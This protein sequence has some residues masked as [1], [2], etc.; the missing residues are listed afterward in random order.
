MTD[1]TPPQLTH[2]AL[3]GAVDVSD[4]PAPLELTVRADDDTAVDYVVA[5]FDRSLATTGG[6]TSFLFVDDGAGTSW[7]DALTATLEV[8]PGA[9]AGPLRLARVWVLDETGESRSYSTAELGALGFDTVAMITS[10]GPSD[11]APP[12]LTWL[13]LPATVDV[14]GGPAPLEIAVS[15]QDES[16]IASALVEFDRPL[17][18]PSG[19]TTAALVVPEADGGWTSGPVARTLTLSHANGPG[20]VAVT[21][22]TLEDAH[23]NITVLD[24]GALRALG[25]DTSVEIV[26]GVA[27]R[28]P[29]ELTNVELAGPVDIT[30]GAARLDYRVAAVDPAGIARATIV[31]DRPVA[32]PGGT[33]RELPLGPEDGVPW[34]A[35]FRAGAAA[36]AGD[37]LPGS[38]GIRAVELVDLAGNAAIYTAADLA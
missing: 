30:E 12:D 9:A 18:T 38:L 6:A 34:E 19:A 16:A 27:D 33:L 7:A 14:S 37:A 21:R 10:D 28:A 1:G 11:T 13:D 32:G 25:V 15:A 8:D 35:G 29:P 31:L 22:V 2:L 26:G 23:R 4:G 5:E 20:P 24:A 36:I 3:T 17:A